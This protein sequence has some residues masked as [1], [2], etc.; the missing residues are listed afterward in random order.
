MKTV[1][2]RLCLGELKKIRQTI[3]ETE[4]EGEDIKDVGFIICS[5]D[6]AIDG[7][8]ELVEKKGDTNE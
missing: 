1:T 4:R 3:L 6:G 5:I 8:E 7:I 2:W